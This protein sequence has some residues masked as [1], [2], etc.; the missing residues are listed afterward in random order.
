MNFGRRPIDQLG[1]R[2][3][4]RW[5]AERASATTPATLRTELSAVRTFGRWL[6]LEGHLRSDPT[7][8]VPTPRVPR[9]VPRALERT[10]VARTLMAC[11]DSRARA[12]V[13]LMVGCGLRR[14]EVAALQLGDVDR[15]AG[16]IYVRGKGGHERIVPLVLEVRRALEA[17]LSDVPATAGA[18]IRQAD[19][20]GA[21]TPTTVGLY[22]QRWMR[23]A[24][25]KRA[26]RD[27]KG[28][29]SFRHTCASDVAERAPDLRVV[30]DMLGHRSL[31]TTQV[32]LRRAKLSD[33]AAAMAGRDYTTPTDAA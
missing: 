31:A 23:D 21:L 7:L 15:G 8:G 24:G 6:A 4:E 17:Y 13:W 1:R 29:H 10:D 14:A 9:T 26:G 12:I 33:M 11:P 3:I 22:V 27:G 18:L 19:G 2:A 20:T 30:Q 16:I 25:V 32:Y 28:C 5:M